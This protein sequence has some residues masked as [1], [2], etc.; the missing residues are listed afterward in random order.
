MEEIKEGSV[1]VSGTG[2]AGTACDFKGSDIA[3]LLRNGDIWIGPVHQ[4][5]IP[6]SQEELDACP[7][8]VDRFEGR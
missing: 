2:Q 7:I 5:H 3:V 1:V 6:Q 8:D 4:C